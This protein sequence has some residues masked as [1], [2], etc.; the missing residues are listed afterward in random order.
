VRVSLPVGLIAPRPSRAR[1]MDKEEE[2]ASPVSI[3]AR[4]DLIIF[5]DAG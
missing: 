5:I 2:R 4:H 3:T 1:G